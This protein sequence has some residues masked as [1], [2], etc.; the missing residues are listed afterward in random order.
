MKYLEMIVNLKEENKDDSAK[1]PCS[2]LWPHHMNEFKCDQGLLR[3]ALI[4]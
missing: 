2:H 3:E 1:M 4:Q